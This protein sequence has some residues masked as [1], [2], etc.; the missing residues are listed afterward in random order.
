MP[1][2]RRSWWVSVSTV[3]STRLVSIGVGRGPIR[4]DRLGGVAGD[5]DELLR[6][7]DAALAVG[8]GVVELLDHRG[9][10]VLEALDDE[11]L[12]ERPGAVER[13]ADEGGGEVEQLP[14]RA[15]VR[16]RRPAEVVVEVEVGFVPPLGRRQPTRGRGPRAGGA[17]AP[18]RRRAGAGARSRSGSGAWSS[19][20]TLAIDELRCGSFSRFHISASTSVIRR[21]LRISRGPSHGPDARTVR[22]ISAGSRC[23]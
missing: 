20:V 7:A 5:V 21:S 13:G 22:R 16:Q 10:A 23:A 11:E 15:G 3:V 14:H 19:S 1:S 12:P 9:P 18:A 4:R 8:D 17:G 6:H 2:P